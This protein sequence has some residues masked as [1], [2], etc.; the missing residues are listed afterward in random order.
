RLGCAKI[1]DLILRCGNSEQVGDVRVGSGMGLVAEE[2]KGLVLAVVDFGNPDGSADGAAEV[3]PANLGAGMG[4]RAGG[5]EIF[6]HPVIVERSMELVGA[7]SHGVA[8]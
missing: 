8:Q 1:P 2:E 6:V 4:V 7:R 3:V 5:V